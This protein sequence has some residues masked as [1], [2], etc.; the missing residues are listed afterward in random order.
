VLQFSINE[1]SK[2]FEINDKRSA[3]TFFIIIPPLPA[4]RNK[5]PTANSFAYRW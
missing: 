5:C 1:K 4:F 2:I 3:A